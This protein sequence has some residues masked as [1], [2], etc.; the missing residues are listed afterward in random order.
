MRVSTALFTCKAHPKPDW[1][2]HGLN[3][4]PEFHESYHIKVIQDGNP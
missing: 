2:T 4:H 1:A 3:H